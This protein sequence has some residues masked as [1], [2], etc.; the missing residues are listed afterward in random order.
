[1][2]NFSPFL[3]LYTLYRPLTHPDPLQ[4]DTFITDRSTHLLDLMIFPLSDDK[5]KDT[6]TL[7]DNGGRQ[8]KIIIVYP[9]SLLKLGDVFV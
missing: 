6:R 7:P 3:L 9:H 5:M 2:L 1:M 4:C 8:G